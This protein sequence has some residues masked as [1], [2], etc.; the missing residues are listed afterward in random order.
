MVGWVLHDNIYQIIVYIYIYIYTYSIFHKKTCA[1]FCC[2]LF[3][4]GSVIGFTWW[5]HQME[6]F[7]ALLALCGGIHW[8]PVNS[9]HKGLWR[10]ALMFSLIYAW[11][12]GWVN[13]REAGDLRRY[14]AHY[15]VIV[16]VDSRQVFAH[17]LQGCFTGTGA[18]RL[19]Q[20]QWSNPEGYR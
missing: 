19:P 12:K 9:P 13:N 17:I 2:A 1:M 6:T 8:S 5:R 11:I 16:M 4:C 18:I 20:C 7:S 10:E 3:C 15:D 14:H